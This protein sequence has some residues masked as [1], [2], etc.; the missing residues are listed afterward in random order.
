MGGI[1]Q[2]NSTYF[3]HLKYPLKSAIFLRK[4]RNY[5]VACGTP[6][7]VREPVSAFLASMPPG[8]RPG[9]CRNEPPRGKLGPLVRRGI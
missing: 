1:I 5:S 3:F 9:K 8:E 4:I 7:V 2:G 6:R